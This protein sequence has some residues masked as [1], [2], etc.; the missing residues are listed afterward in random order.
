MA[1]PNN[2]FQKRYEETM[3][4]YHVYFEHVR[5]AFK[6]HCR[7]IRNDTLAKL[8]ETAEDDKEVRKKILID[9]K[10]QLDE[11]LAE[12]KQLLNFQSSKMRKTLEEIRRQQDEQKFDLDDE[13]A[14]IE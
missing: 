4:K 13:L 2:P 7:E 10:K 12:L 8:K 14:R 9:Q 1:D 6:G 11:T 5:T 3:A